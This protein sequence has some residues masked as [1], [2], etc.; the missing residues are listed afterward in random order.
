MLKKIWD[1]LEEILGSLI[2]TVMLVIT[3]AN[4]LTRY[5]ITYPLAFTEEI[6]IS[7]FVW[8]VLLG[9]AIA[10]RTNAHLAMTF[11]YDF[12]P[13]SVKKVFF[14]IST[15]MSI[16]FFSLLVWLGSVQ[17]MDELDLNVTSQALGI[18]VS[19]YS[20][21]VPLLSILVI[22]RIIQAARITLREKSF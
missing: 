13:N 16:V 19:V 4:V 20:I 22:I 12:M 10:F 15:A 9:T 17:V 6:T 11:F 3:F 5:L 21:G 7:M 8:V 18:P 2:L 14:I 1:H